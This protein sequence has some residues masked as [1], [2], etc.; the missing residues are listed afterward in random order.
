MQKI[1]AAVTGVDLDQRLL[2]DVD[3]RPHLANP[4]ASATEV[5]HGAEKAI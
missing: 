3:R 2:K 5:Q 1:H 4:E